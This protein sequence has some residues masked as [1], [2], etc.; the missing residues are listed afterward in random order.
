MPPPFRA[1]VCTV[2]SRKPLPKRSARQ[3]L[4]QLADAAS[5]PK[6]ARGEQVARDPGIARTEVVGSVCPVM[7]RNRGI[8]LT[9]GVLAKASAVRPRA[10]PRPCKKDTHT[11]RTTSRHSAHPA[12]C[13]AQPQLIHSY[14]HTFV[15]SYIHTSRNK[16]SA[17]QQNAARD[18]CTHKFTCLHCSHVD[19]SRFLRSKFCIPSFLR[20]CRRYIAKSGGG[21]RRPPGI[22]TRSFWQSR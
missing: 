8:S 3:G 16:R 15:H 17:A 5:D 9:E 2:Y 7:R 6:Q 13:P 14:I 20:A 4:T 21:D 18:A 1:L 12:R 22:Q 10:T 19:L 11:A